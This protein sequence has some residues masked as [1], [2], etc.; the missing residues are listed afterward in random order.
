MALLF[1]SVFL[2]LNVEFPEEVESYDCVDV[3]D[4]CQKHHCQHQLK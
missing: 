4:D 2:L 3:Y 1:S